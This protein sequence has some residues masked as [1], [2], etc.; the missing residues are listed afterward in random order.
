MYFLNNRNNN[1]VH[2]RFS[3]FSSLIMVFNTSQVKHINE[4][5]YL[6]DFLF[7]NENVLHHQK[8]ND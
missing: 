1:N 2:S 7:I 5:K 4:D 6:I 8:Q 3:T